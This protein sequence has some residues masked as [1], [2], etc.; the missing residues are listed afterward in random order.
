VAELLGAIIAAALMNWM[1]GRPE[2]SGPV[3]MAEKKL[4]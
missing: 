1:L 4:P 2:V 3:R